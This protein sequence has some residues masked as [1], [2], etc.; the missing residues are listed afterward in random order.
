MPWVKQKWFLYFNIFNKFCGCIELTIV[1]KQ[2]KKTLSHFLTK[3]RVSVVAD[4]YIYI[5][6]LCVKT[7]LI[8]WTYLSLFSKI[9]FFWVEYNSYTIN[10]IDKEFYV[11]VYMLR[12]WRYY[13]VIKNCAPYSDYR[14]LDTSIKNT[15]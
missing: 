15:E 8:R 1:M 5:Y 6:I 9:P 11:N 12:L 10:W 3:K 2:T 4:I 13:V 14:L 7:S